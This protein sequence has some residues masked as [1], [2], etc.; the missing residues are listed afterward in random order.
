MGGEKIE[1][2]EIIEH[3]C[4]HWLRQAHRLYFE[5]ATTTVTEGVA[6]RDQAY[7]PSL[8]LR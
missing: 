2:T 3:T 7:L 1:K 6:N 5:L 4:Q 8:L